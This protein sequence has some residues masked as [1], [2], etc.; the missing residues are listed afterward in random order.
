MR[1]CYIFHVILELNTINNYLVICLH[2]VIQ[3]FFLALHRNKKGS[4]SNYL[5]NAY[6]NRIYTTKT[7]QVIIT[8]FSNNKYCFYTF[9][10]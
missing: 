4:V 5:L 2:L 10:F 1:I 7:I 8:F 3:Q 6:K 9:Y